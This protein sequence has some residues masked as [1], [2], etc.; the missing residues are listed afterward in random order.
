MAALEGQNEEMETVTTEVRQCATWCEL[1]SLAV[2]YT[3]VMRLILGIFMTEVAVFNISFPSHPP[4]YLHS[5]NKL[6]E[7][8]FSENSNVTMVTHGNVTTVTSTH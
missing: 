4:T 1:S 8:L 6:D 5:L 2:L 7:E 3:V